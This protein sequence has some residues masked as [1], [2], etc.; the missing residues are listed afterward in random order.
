MKNKKLLFLSLMATFALV[1]T[2]CDKTSESNKPS[3][4]STA[5]PSDSSTPEKVISSSVNED[6]VVVFDDKDVYDATLEGYDVLAAEADSKIDSSERAVIYAQAEAKLLNSAVMV[7]TTTKGGTNTISRIVPRTVPYAF[8]GCDQDSFKGMKIV[9]KLITKEVREAIIAQWKTDRSSVLAGGTAVGS[10]AILSNAGYSFIEKYQLTF[11]EGPETLDYIETSSAADTEILCQLV[12]RLVSYDNFG[13]IVPA[14][15]S[16]WE[17]NDDYTEFTYHIRQNVKWVKAD[18]TDTGW[19]VKAKDF[20]TGFQHCLD[21]VESASYI[22]DGMVVKAHEYMKGTATIDEV[23][24][25]ATDDYTLKITLENPAP[26]FESIL[27][28]N[29][30]MPICPEFFA[31]KGGVFGA[32]ALAAARNEGTYKFGTTDVN[33][34]LYCGAYRLA[35][36]TDGSVIDLRANESY[37]ETA[38]VTV[39]QIKEIYDD[40]S[41]PTAAFENV[42]NGTYSGMGLSS[43]TLPLAKANAE[44]AKCIYISDTD[45]TTYFCGINLNRQTF[46]LSTGGLESSKTLAEK[47]ATKYALLNKNFRNAI[48]HAFDRATF[49]SIRLGD[50]LKLNNLRNMYTQPTFV[51]ILKETAGY[52]AGLTY[53][54]VVQ[55]EL[56]KLGS[57]IQVADSQE[58][59]YN[60]TKA[61]AYIDA[62]YEELKDN[63]NI[64]W[65]VKIEV[66]TYSKSEVMMA[67]AGLFK[68]SVEEALGTDKVAVT[69]FS[70][71]NPN[72]YYAAGYRAADGASADY[73]VFYGSGWGP[74]YADPKS[75]IDTFLPEGSG[76]MTKV[77]GL[78]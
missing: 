75:Y 44:V 68:K 76:Y 43:I 34:I 8:F 21:G 69:I 47:N 20:V 64:S 59:W 35:E 74:D 38:K 46:K 17:I 5:S 15:A 33:S 49:N 6:G 71:E 32:A 18:G 37:Y 42:V 54:D 58:G 26:Y 73:D 55:A 1:V 4:S 41:N 19:F 28:Y 27:S 23:G 72:D 16:S 11:N 63:A 66:L 51:S 7:P 39:K 70:T 65:P 62:A 36:Y 24:V 31:S 61:K 67:E 13:Q 77:I 22:V 10:D 29:L 25:K 53:G 40:G 56:V 3:D 50:D 2:G 57:S 14:L 12:D 60:A 30:F 45:T 52:A 48:L 78:W 9:D